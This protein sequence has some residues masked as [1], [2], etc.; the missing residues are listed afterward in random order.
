M[1]GVNGS[2]I[3]IYLDG[4]TI[5]TGKNN[6]GAKALEYHS[7][8]LGRLENVV[9]RSGDGQGV[10]GLDLTHHDVGPALVKHVTI[11]G[12]EV[13]SQIHYQEYSM[14]LEQIT[15]RHQKVVGI[16]NRG[17]I[18]AIR[19]LHSDNTVTAIEGEGP[20]SMITLLDSELIGGSPDQPAIRSE[21]A[22]YALRVKTRGYRSAIEK[23]TLN[24][25]KPAAWTESRIA[26]PNIDEY[27]GDQI[28][29]GFGSPTGALK[30]EI[31]ET[32]EPPVPPVGEWVNV[33]RF[34]DRVMNEDWGPAL[35]AAIDSGARVIYL[36]R[37][38]VGRFSTPVR[39]HGKVERLIG[40]GGELHWNEAVWKGDR[41]RH[42]TQADLA[43]STTTD[44]R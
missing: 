43:P 6:P 38:E 42:Q 26:G 1:T 13:G 15:L 27:I 40:L 18:L 4:V 36:P 16:R 21:G 11:D 22:L 9:L 25:Q 7:N 19:Q 17:N 20:N 33:I 35:Q 29:S 30:L 8:N 10:M 39:L 14:T 3:S 37:G 31:E 34:R 12:F 28:L 44:F 5:D 2:S 23:R 24:N 32:P 41:Q